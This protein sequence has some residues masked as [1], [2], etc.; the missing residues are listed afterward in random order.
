[1]VR[2]AVLVSGLAV[3]ETDLA[4]P[5]PPQVSAPGTPDPRP[6]WAL[7]ALA[8]LSRAAHAA[9]RGLPMPDVDRA[10]EPLL[11]AVRRASA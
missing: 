7:S 11:A 2:Q 6:A 1:M 9:G 3:L 10:A 8:V 4:S 5:P